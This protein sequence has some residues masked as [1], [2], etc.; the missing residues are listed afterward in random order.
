MRP[1][2]FPRVAIVLMVA[3]SLTI[4]AAIGLAAEMSRTVQSGFGGPNLPTMWWSKLPMTFL[5]VF[6][7]LWIAGAIGYGILFALRWTGL[8]RL[9]NVVTWPQPRQ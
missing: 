1:F 6:L 2:R 5:L 4:L 7:F 9:S 3:T 8:H